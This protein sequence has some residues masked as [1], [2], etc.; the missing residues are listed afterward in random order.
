[1]ITSAQG[2][3]EKVFLDFFNRSDGKAVEIIGEIQVK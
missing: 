1:M 3:V 2:S